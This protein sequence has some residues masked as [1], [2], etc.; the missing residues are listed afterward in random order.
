MAP[1]ARTLMGAWRQEL[2]W[3]HVRLSVPRRG[4]PDAAK[5]P[6]SLFGRPQSDLKEG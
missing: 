2:G 5:L 3:Q 4:N 1:G 6:P